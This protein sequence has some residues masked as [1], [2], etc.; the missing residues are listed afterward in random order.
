MH[1]IILLL[2]LTFTSTVWAKEQPTILVYNT[3]TKETVLSENADAVRPMASITKL[4]TA[5]IALDQYE[6]T[7]KLP[8][9]KTSSV[10]VEQ[11]LTRLL[12]R[13][14]NAASEILA[15]NYPNGRAA[16]IA[17]M[18]ART[19]QLGLI[20]TEFSDPSG[21]V[22]TNITTARELTKIVTAAGAYSFIRRVS[23]QA[24][25]RQTSESKKKTKTIILANTNKS[26]LFE[27]NNIL[28]SKTGFT[29][30]AGRCLAMLVDR[31]GQEHVI[32]ILGEPTKLARDQVARNLLLP[33]SA[34]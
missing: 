9:S 2:L 11:L 22:A 24:E 29:N 15:R 19:Q 14:D 30:K 17:A 32:I 33:N 18:N 16:F 26:I 12:V 10:T 8:V 27:F 7:A 13:S 5:M 1:N 4:M 6:L 23:S 20:N 28:I 31:N 21:L 25:V 34:N 3:A